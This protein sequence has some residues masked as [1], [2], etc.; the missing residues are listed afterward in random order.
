M[1]DLEIVGEVKV[2]R[3]AHFT[4]YEYKKISPVHGIIYVTEIC[5]N[6]RSAEI[7]ENGYRVKITK[8]F[9]TK[10]SVRDTTKIEYHKSKFEVR[11]DQ[12]NA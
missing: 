1:S 9:I 6:S 7:T 5:Y 12:N 8:S 4:A 10:K 2:I 11:E 3:S